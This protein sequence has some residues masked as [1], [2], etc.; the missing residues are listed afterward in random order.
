M[1]TNTTPRRGRQWTW[2]PAKPK[3]VPKDTKDD[4]SAKAKQLVE[5]DLKPCYVQPP[6][7]RPRWNYI[8]DIFTKWRGIYFYFVARYARPGP[9]AISPFFETGFARL[10]YLSNGHFNLAYARHTGEWLQVR[11]DMTLAG[12][13]EAIRTEPTFHP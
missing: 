2:A 7:K 11:R 9:N 10:E 4:V 8:V 12:A 3:A 13:L 6:P 5:M 1:N